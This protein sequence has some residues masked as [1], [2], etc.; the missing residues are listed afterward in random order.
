MFKDDRLRN[1]DTDGETVPTLRL[2]GD[3]ISG[4]GSR[5]RR[6]ENTTM[7]PAFGH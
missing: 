2:T 6:A 4:T 1:G 7:W 5:H 3:R